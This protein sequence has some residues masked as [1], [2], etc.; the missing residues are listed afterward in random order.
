MMENLQFKAG[1]PVRLKEEVGETS[2]VNSHEDITVVGY[3][4]L[5]QERFASTR[6]R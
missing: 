4:Q 2:S 1:A 6:K 3:T 5:V